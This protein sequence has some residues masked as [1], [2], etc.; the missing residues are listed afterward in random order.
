MARSD[1]AIDDNGDL[2]ITKGDFSIVSPSDDNHIEDL[3]AFT[4]GSL[5]QF[6]WVGVG[7]SR[8]YFSSG[9][10]QKIQRMSQV[11]LQADGYSIVP[12]VQYGQNGLVTITVT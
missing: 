10:Q 4:P 12:I 2:L 7:L 11:C 6:P 5:K 1:F 9:L 3:I 8:F